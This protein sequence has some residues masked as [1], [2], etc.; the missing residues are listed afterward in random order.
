MVS[1]SNPANVDLESYCPLLQDMEDKTDGSQ[2]YSSTPLHEAIISDN[3][4]RLRLLLIGGHGPNIKDCLDETPLHAAVDVAGPKGMIMCRML[5]SYG[6]DISSTDALGE[7]TFLKAVREDKLDMV[8]FLQSRGADP[9]AVNDSGESALHVLCASSVPSL[10]M[11]DQLVRFHV[12]INGRNSEGETPLHI[13]CRHG[14]LELIKH[15]LKLHADINAVDN[16]GRTPYQETNVLLDARIPCTIFLHGAKLNHLQETRLF[17]DFWIQVWM[18][19]DGEQSF[20]PS[21]AHEDVLIMAMLTLANRP[22]EEWVMI[23]VQARKEAAKAYR[24]CVDAL[25]AMV[26]GS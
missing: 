12:A 1:S 26:T 25:V 15:L 18:P 16:A 21:P 7:T 10:F 2:C 13:A 23:P 6:A 9:C 19:W 11:L 14:H 20:L 5:L 22:K 17:H 4:S 24:V 8:L 3:I